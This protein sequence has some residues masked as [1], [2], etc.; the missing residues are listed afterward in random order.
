MSKEHFK[1][2]RHS[3]RVMRRKAT[4]KEAIAWVA[5]YDMHSAEILK[6]IYGY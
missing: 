5:F 4:H 6:I 3:Y 1:N 2:L